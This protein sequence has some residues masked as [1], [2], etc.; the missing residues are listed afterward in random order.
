MGTYPTNGQQ[1]PNDWDQQLK[2]Y[3]DDLVDG[4]Q[5][6]AADAQESADDALIAVGGKVNVADVA[7]E[8]TTGW[9]RGIFVDDP[10]DIPPGTP[11]NTL[12]IVTGA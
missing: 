12:V 6:M 11:V 5:S 7:D 4:A 2:G 9:V 3:I 1:S 10:E 8:G